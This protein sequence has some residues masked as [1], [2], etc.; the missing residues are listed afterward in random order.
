M[1]QKP[2][3]RRRLLLIFFQLVLITKF[4]FFLRVVFICGLVNFMLHSHTITLLQEPTKK[5]KKAQKEE[6]EWD[7]ENERDRA[8]LKLNELMQLDVCRLWPMSCTEETFVK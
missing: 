2:K 8:V 4:T 3:E 6:K 1:K 7:W 5:G